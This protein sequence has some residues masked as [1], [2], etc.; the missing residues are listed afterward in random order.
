[1]LYQFNKKYD[2]VVGNPPY[3]KLTK[4]K[5]LLSLYKSESY[6]KDTNNIFSFFI[7]KAMRIGNIVSLVV[8]KSLINAPEFNTTRLLMKEKRLSHIIDFGEKGFKGVKIETIC[9]ILDTR[10]NRKIQ[11]LNLNITNS[12]D[13]HQATY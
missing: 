5:E 1:M 13:E 9:F 6:N 4:E 12:V 2:I 3:K 11:L 7:E 10:K 8:P